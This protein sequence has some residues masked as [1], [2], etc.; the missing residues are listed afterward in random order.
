MCMWSL[1]A[2]L[3]HGC[4]CE[5]GVVSVG[6]LLIR[7]LLCWLYSRAP[8]VWKLP[9]TLFSTWKY[10]PMPTGLSTSRTHTLTLKGR[11][12]PLVWGLCMSHMDIWTLETL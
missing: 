6:V 2:L 9:C 11:V 12:Y 1:G 7:A 8:D 5:L 4:L 3:L 10:P